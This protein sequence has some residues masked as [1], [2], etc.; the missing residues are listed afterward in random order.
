LHLP[1]EPRGLSQPGQQRQA[2]QYQ[3]NPPNI[4]TVMIINSCTS[5]VA[6]PDFSIPDRW[7]QRPHIPDQ[8]PQ[9]KNSSIFKK[10]IVMKYDPGSL[11]QIQA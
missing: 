10:K 6:D 1:R 5:S 4:L 8:D 2:I 7:S 11:S 9:Q 3:G